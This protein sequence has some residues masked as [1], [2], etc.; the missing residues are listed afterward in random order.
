M[1]P[2]THAPLHDNCSQ[3]TDGP[4]SKKALRRVK[5]ISPNALASLI[6]LVARMLHSRGY[7]EDMFPAQW[8]ALR[9]FAR[10]DSDKRTASDL[11]RF[12]GL[13]NGPVSRTVRTLVLKGLLAKTEQQP[14]GRSEWLEVT[15]A[16]MALLADDPMKALEIALADLDEADRQAA[17]RVLDTVIRAMSLPAH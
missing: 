7:A 16:G 14:K 5:P 9:Y 10:A 17:A 12:Q 13:A 3:A 4:T 11:A 15:D 8:A 1:L 2:Q 6:A